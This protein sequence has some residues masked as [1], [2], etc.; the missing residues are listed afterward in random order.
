MAM[1]NEFAALVQVAFPWNADFRAISE[2]RDLREFMLQELQRAVYVDTRTA[3][4]CSLHP[5]GIVCRGI[6][7]PEVTDTWKG[8]LNGCLDH[9]VLEKFEPQVATWEA[10]SVTNHSEIAFVIGDNRKDQAIPPVY[11][12][13]LVWDQ[14]SWAV[15]LVTQDWWPD[16]RRCVELHFRTHPGMRARPKALE[17]PI[18][19]ECAPRFWRTL[20]RF[21]TG[22]NLRARF[23]E[24]LTKRVYGI[25][26]A[27]LGEEP[28]GDFRR[29]RVTRSWRVHY[30][31]EN[32]YL[33]L[34]EFGPHSIG[35]VD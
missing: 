25:L 4:E 8:L 3:Y 10:D 19:F 16:L 1:S 35:G 14:D 27:S 12:F 26:D 11:T 24:A 30:R 15:R 22:E 18:P 21:C 2:L 13:P 34:E 5:E 17:Q 31:V 9:A 6:E 28:L 29:F 7:D 20:E 33:V 23:I 32:K